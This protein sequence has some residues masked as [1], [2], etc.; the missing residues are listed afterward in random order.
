MPRLRCNEHTMNI[1]P[2]CVF[3]VVGVLES[4]SLQVSQP[5]WKGGGILRPGKLDKRGLDAPMCQETPQG[6]ILWTHWRS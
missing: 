2:C 5:M 3:C 4:C 6:P 1:N